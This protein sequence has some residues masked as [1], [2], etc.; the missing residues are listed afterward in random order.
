MIIG[1][2]VAAVLCGTL[3]AL[4]T[5]A[6]AAPAA[7]EPVRET[8]PPKVNFVLDVSGSMAERDIDGDTRMNAAKRAFNDVIDFIPEGVHFG[9]RTLGAD[10][11]GD[12]RLGRGCVDS[13]QL[14]PV[15]PVDRT[16]A[17]TAVATLAPTGWTPIGYALQGAVRDL[18]DGDGM[19][20]IVLI[21]DGEDSC[22]DP[23]PCE[24]ARELAAAGIGLT[25]D[26]L[27]LTPADSAVREQLGCIAEATGGTYTAVQDTDQLADRLKQIVE[28]TA[29]VRVETP[30]VVDGADECA[31]APLLGA[32]VYSDR[33]EFGEHRRYRV[34]VAPGRELRAS[35]S[36]AADRPM[37]RD[38]GVLLRLLAE[39]GRE[40]VRGSTAGH[41]RTDVIATG[42]RHPSDA[43]SEETLCLE[44]SHAFSAPDDVQRTPGMPVELTVDLVA[45]ADTPSDVAAF[46]L[47]RGWIPLLVLTLTGL[48]AGIL[49]GLI[50]RVLA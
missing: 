22:G 24:V 34:Q 39:D 38:H 7:A 19:R 28:R 20:R 1:R 42:L 40:L 25:I 33:Q 26:T 30:T 45:A 37:N 32:G 18:G 36:V 44:V 13:S 14:Y 8:D 11:P 5:G 46:G 12:D 43:D 9:I 27:G 23:E 47:A 4:M 41:G 15:G 2:R 50:R 21:T 17:K 10:Y 16:E 3:A 29:E 49:W 6:L 31:D 48:A 35:V